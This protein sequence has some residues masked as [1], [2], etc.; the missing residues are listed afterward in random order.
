MLERK[1]KGV[2]MM[3]SMMVFRFLGA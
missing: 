2:I 3:K 1:S